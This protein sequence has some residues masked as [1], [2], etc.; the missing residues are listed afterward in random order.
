MFPSALC[1]FLTLQFE[2]SCERPV[3]RAALIW[4]SSLQPIEKL[5]VKLRKVSVC[6]WLLFDTGQNSSPTRFARVKKFLFT[7]SMY[8][9]VN[10]KSEYMAAERAFRADKPLPQK[11]MAFWVDE[12]KKHTRN[13]TQPF[14]PCMMLSK[15]NF[16]T[17]FAAELCYL[18]FFCFLT[19]SIMVRWK[20]WLLNRT[21]ENDLKRCTHRHVRI[22]SLQETF[23][24]LSTPWRLRSSF[25]PGFLLI[26]EQFVHDQQQCLA[27]RQG[28]QGVAVC[29]SPFNTL[30]A[31]RAAMRQEAHE[32]FQSPISP[33]P[34]PRC[35]LPAQLEADHKAVTA[36]HLF[37]IGELLQ[38]NTNWQRN[39]L[40]CSS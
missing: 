8:P 23:N 25:Y 12:W 21:T 5:D 15:Q 11:Y 30:C 10:I 40:V 28:I 34:H 13:C 4:K 17:L 1:F 22:H 3:S 37:R 33:H 24:Q 31:R 26:P 29:I 7:L 18:S 6:V 20:T 16:R 35:N 14:M 9:C 2:Y 39:V 36:T 32:E 38:T 27:Y 19:T